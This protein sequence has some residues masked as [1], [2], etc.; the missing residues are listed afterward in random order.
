MMSGAVAK[1]KGEEDGDAIFLSWVV[2][3]YV[4]YILLCRLYGE[5]SPI[6]WLLNWKMSR[7]ANTR[8]PGGLKM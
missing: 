3:R 7:R 4:G 2:V 8:L 1:G 5:L 6:F